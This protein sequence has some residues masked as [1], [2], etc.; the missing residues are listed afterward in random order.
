MDQTE[1]D[2]SDRCEALRSAV[3]VRLGLVDDGDVPFYIEG[4]ICI[5]LLPKILHGSALHGLDRGCLGCKV[6]CGART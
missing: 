3:A 5:P 4:T 6:A 2:H 1:K